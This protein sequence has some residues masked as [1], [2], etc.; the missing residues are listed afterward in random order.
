[1]QKGL[2]ADVE[3]DIQTLIEQ[4]CQ[5]VLMKKCLQLMAQ[6]LTKF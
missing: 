2:V 3:R 6:F 5:E 4:A 1:M